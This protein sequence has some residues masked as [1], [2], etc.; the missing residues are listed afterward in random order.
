MPRLDADAESF[1]PGGDDTS[2]V[3]ARVLIGCVIILLALGLITLVSIG[4]GQKSPLHYPTRQAIFAVVALLGGVFTSQI[5]VGWWKRLL[6]LMFLGTSVLLILA[7]LIGP[8]INGAHRWLTLGPIN[9]QPSEFAK[10]TSVVWLALWMSRYRRYTHE[11][12]LGFIVPGAGLGVL[13]L[14][15]FIGPDFGTTA[16][17]AGTGGIMMFIAGTRIS[18]LFLA[19]L[20]GGGAFAV[21]VMQDPIRLARVISF[22]EPEKYADKE[23]YQLMSSLHGFMQGGWKGVGFGQ[24]LQKYSYLPEAHTD[25]ILAII[26]EEWG[27]F[28]TLAVILLFIIFFICGMSISWRSRDPF[29]R[30]TGFGI[31]LVITLQAAINVGVVTGAMPTKGLA[32]PFI[33][34]GGSNLVFMVAMVGILVRIA[35]GSDEESSPRPASDGR[36][37][38]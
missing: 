16:L 18:L 21:L 24:S 3:A 19:A 38:M 13:C 2:P 4:I 6:P 33:S 26:G 11:F 20:L 23:A 29:A 30:L 9:F 14:L 7:R 22:M 32:L 28:G 10:L 37:W 17:I 15:V 36:S 1:L 27:L 12:V 5:P 35:A 8:E 31:T 25:F 34:H